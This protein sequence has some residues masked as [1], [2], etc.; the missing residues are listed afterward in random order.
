MRRRDQRARPPL[1][2]RTPVP[3]AGPPAMHAPLQVPH[4]GS[5]EGVDALLEP[6]L[7]C[8]QYAE[9][10]NALKNVPTRTRG[11]LPQLYSS[12]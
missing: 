3:S 12:S 10:L 9:P 4:L 6:Q 2:L 7:R 8:L 5:C 11:P 1:P